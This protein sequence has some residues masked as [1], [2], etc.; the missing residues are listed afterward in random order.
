[1]AAAPVV[2]PQETT[3]PLSEPA[4]VINTFIAPRKTF[5]DL[6][7][8]AAWWAP[9]VL[10]V[11]VSVLFV[12][13]GDKKVGFRKILENQLQSQPKQ[14]AQLENLPA[15]Q[16]EQQ[17]QIRTKFSGVISYIF[18]VFTLIVWLVMAAVLFGTVKLGGDAGVKFKT[19]LALVIYGGLPGLIKVLLAILSLAAGVSTDSFTFQNPVATNPG[20]FIDPAGNPVL[21]AFLSSFDVFTIWTLV[22]VSI[23]LTC[24]SKVKSG[25][26][27]AMVFGWFAV[28]V[29]LGT[30]I[31]A[32]F[33]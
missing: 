21:K 18:P 3:A 16:R 28:V 7:R 15:D 1:M 26:A 24:I 13:A 12:Y 23:G 2:P 27:Y 33:A 4:R 29:L 14:A 31:A 11:I 6:N 25:K 5:V 17:M 9:F 20:Y 19:V 32:A 30:G 8:S 10:T 22:L